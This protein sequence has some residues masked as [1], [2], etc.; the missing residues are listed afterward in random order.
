MDGKR[1][2]DYMNKLSGGEIIYGY[3]QSS[4]RVLVI[5]LSEDESSI[6]SYE[7]AFNALK[8]MAISMQSLLVDI[9]DDM[10][11]DKAAGNNGGG[12]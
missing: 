3:D 1:M 2:V 11:N 7:K 6:M 10:I 8:Q 9:I 12:K 5:I 4:N